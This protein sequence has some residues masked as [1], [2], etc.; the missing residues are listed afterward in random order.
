MSDP[1]P[2]PPR[3][4][5]ELFIGQD[6]L[7]PVWSL[8][9][10]LILAFA[11]VNVAGILVAPLVHADSHAITIPRI[12]FS[13]G[14]DVI[15]LTLAAFIVSRVE[16]RPFAAYG[17]NGS[18]LIKNLTQ[19]LITGLVALSLLIGCLRAANLLTFDAVSLHGPQA[20]ISGI[21]WAG[22]FLIVG[23]FEEFFFRGFLQY[24]V[25]RIFARITR[26][27]S[28]TSPYTSQIGFALAALLLSGIY[29]AK[30]HTGNHGETAVGILAVGIAG[31]TFA[32]SLW[33]TGSLWWAIGFHAAWDWAQSFL[34]GVADS[35]G[36]I[37]GHF[38]AAH[39][40]GPAIL[41][42]GATGPE[43]SIFVIP[44]LLLVALLVHQT[45]PKLGTP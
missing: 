5:L 26:R 43:G 44:T 40:T 31:L 37:Q 7:R 45:H 30:V 23:L 19:G 36:M 35:G 42:G 13:D 18:R 20:L 1:A 9:L 41:S 28:P 8:L 11:I 21:Q 12:L 38:L 4:F 16:R 25:A 27:I 39:P 32:F 10:F 6:G 24:T 29:F 33:R 17:L 3:D 34:Y 22:A 2:R 14:I 15:A